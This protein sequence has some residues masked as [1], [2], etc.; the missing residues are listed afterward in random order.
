MENN[1]FNDIVVLKRSGQRVNFNETKV[2]LAI[3]KG[4]DSV[5]EDYDEKIV[6]KVVESLCAEFPQYVNDVVS[7]EKIIKEK[8]VTE[9][10]VYY[11]MQGHT[12]KDN[13]VIPLLQKLSAELVDAQIECISRST[14]A[15]C[16][17]EN[18]L[19]YYKNAIVPLKYTLDA[20]V[21]Y[22]RTKFYEKILSDI[23]SMLSSR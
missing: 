19:V 5:Y 3:K 16:V 9:D 22:K 14:V 13:V 1:F 23:N 11:Y 17:K 4:F 12:L 18:Q 21:G 15:D 10:T 7:F 2:A 8:G 20:N 6:N